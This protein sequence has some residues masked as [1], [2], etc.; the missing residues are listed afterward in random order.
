MQRDD[1]KCEPDGVTGD[2]GQPQAVRDRR[3]DEPTEGMQ[4]H[5]LRRGNAAG[6]HVFERCGRGEDERGQQA[7]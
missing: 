5:V 1:L 7:Q 6:A 3:P 2:A 4:V